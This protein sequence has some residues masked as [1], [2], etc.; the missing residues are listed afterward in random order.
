MVAYWA[1]EGATWFKFLGGETRAE[2]AAGI[3]EAHS[4]GLKVTGHLC[5]VTFT[6]ASELG[7][8]LLQHGFI[9]NSDYVPGKK[10]DV[11]PPENMKVQADVDVN[12]PEVQASIRAIVSHVYVNRDPGL[13]GVSR[14]SEF[15]GVRFAEQRDKIARGRALL[16][17]QGLASDVW[18][19]PSHSFD[20]NTLQ[21]LRETGFRVVT[22]GY[23]PFPYDRAGLR[24]VP[25]QMAFPRPIPMAAITVCIHA[26]NTSDAYFARIERFLRER[27]R[28]VV[29]FDALRR[30]PARGVW[31]RNLERGVLRAR[32]LLRGPR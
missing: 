13:L 16:E 21:A 23:A 27:R 11:C 8:D 31:N 28:M 10:P 14:N 29:D 2:L 6:E 7:I 26:N 32:A 9:T 20:D 4:R 18:M 30:M 15:A 12:S 24:F 19:A 22:D 3:K 1:S 5:S 25:C 17:A